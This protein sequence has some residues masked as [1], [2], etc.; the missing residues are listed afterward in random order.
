MF[1]IQCIICIDFFC[2]DVS[3]DI[4]FFGQFLVGCDVLLVCCCVEVMECVMEGLFQIFGINCKVGMDVFFD[5]ILFVGSIIV[6]L[7]G[8]WMVWEVCNIGMLK[9]QVV[10]MVGNIGI[11]WVFGMILFVGV[12]FD[13]FFCL[14]ICNLKIIKC[15]L[16]WYYLLSVILQG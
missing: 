8:G 10:W 12:I 14:N 6:V 11:D 4:S 5:L 7:F 15:Y 2:F 1:M 9:L 16:D 3:F 13:F